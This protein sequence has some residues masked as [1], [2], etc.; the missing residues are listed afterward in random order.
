MTLVQAEIKKVY[1][2]TKQVRPYTPAT[3][4]SLNKTFISL[5]TAGQT[6]QL[7]ATFTPSWATSIIVSWVSSDT[8]VATVDNNGLVTCVTPWS[9]TIT[10]TSSNWLTATCSVIARKDVYVDYLLIWGGWGW[11]WWYNYAWW[12]GW[13]GWWFIECC[14]YEIQP[15][16]YV[17]TIWTWWAAWGDYSTWKVWGDSCFN[18]IVAYGWWWGGWYYC[19]WSQWASG[20][21]WGTGN[22]SWWAHKCYQWCYGWT[23]SAYAWAWGWWFSAIGGNAN[24]TTGGVWWCWKSSSI[25]WA[26]M[27]YSWWWWGWW[28]YNAWC[29]WIWWCWSGCGR[30]QS[31]CYGWGWWWWDNCSWSNAW[32][33]WMPWIFILRYPTACGYYV[34]GWTC[35][36][37]WD[38]TIHCFTSSWTLTVN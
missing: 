5:T 27:W 14:N 3:A 12:G 6:E 24:N 8:S 1:L 21:W 37:C 11:G 35:Y 38:Y 7:T 2:G 23:W 18:G 25:S 36:T 28:Y 17:V 34:S 19:R 4:I 33:A 10:A 15:W 30:R 29:H 9:C 13:G 31:C 32:W 20:W 26:E 22:Q 16:S